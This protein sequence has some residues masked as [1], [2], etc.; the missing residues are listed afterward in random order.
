MNDSVTVSRNVKGHLTEKAHLTEILVRLRL[1]KSIVKVPNVHVK[2]S[3]P[4]KFFQFRMFW[5]SRAFVVCVVVAAI[6]LS[7]CGS[8]CWHGGKAISKREA[9]HMKALGMDV[10]C[11]P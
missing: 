9:Q 2:P 4:Q 3:L 5:G 1:V 6:G 7:G 10:R 8:V 11:E